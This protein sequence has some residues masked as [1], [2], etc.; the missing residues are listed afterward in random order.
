MKLQIK[1]IFN[2]NLQKRRPPSFFANLH[3]TLKLMVR[4]FKQSEDP[5]NCDT[6]RNIERLLALNGME[7]MDLIHEVWFEK[8]YNDHVPKVFYFCLGSS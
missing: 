2:I 4:C 3:E 5:S 6:L 7:T 8:Q 1:R